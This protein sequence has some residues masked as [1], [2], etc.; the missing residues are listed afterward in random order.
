MSNFPSRVTAPSPVQKVTREGLLPLAQ[1]GELDA[2]RQ[3]GKA[4]NV[5]KL[6]QASEIVILG[7]LSKLPFF[8]CKKEVTQIKRM[9]IDD[10][11]E[12]RYRR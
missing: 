11:R 8:T 7:K 10:V 2:W 5:G 3:W 9:T 1:G 12:T 4:S 6:R